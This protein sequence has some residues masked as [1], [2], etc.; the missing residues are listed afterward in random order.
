MSAATTA[1]DQWLYSYRY[2]ISTFYPRLTVTIFSFL[3]LRQTV[4]DCCKVWH[5]SRYISLAIWIHSEL[6]SLGSVAPRLYE[7]SYTYSIQ[8]EYE[9]TSS[10]ASEHNPFCYT[11]TIYDL[12]I[13]VLVLEQGYLY[14]L[15]A[16]CPLSFFCCPYITR[17]VV[18]NHSPEV[19]YRVYSQRQIRQLVSGWNRSIHEIYS[20]AWES[21]YC[22][23]VVDSWPCCK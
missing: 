16:A 14:V 9:V 6:L 19:S 15:L 22:S 18:Y 7:C 2:I 23:N 8:G 3:Q 13:I 21:A 4:A 12:T 11:H 1:V 5:F 10:P 20:Q 17:V